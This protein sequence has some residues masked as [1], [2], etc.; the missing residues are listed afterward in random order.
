[1]VFAAGLLYERQWWDYLDGQVQGVFG[2]GNTTGLT[3]PTGQTEPTVSSSAA[4]SEFLLR[5]DQD[6]IPDHCKDNH[7]TNHQWKIVGMWRVINMF[8]VDFGP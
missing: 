5:K 7:L 1:M 8:Y 4:A 3:K 6:A 2:Y